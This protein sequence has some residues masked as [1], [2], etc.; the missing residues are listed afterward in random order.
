MTKPQL[1]PLLYATIFLLSL[2][3]FMQT[4]MTAFAAAPIMGEVGMSP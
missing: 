2:F 4:G 1:G 3:E